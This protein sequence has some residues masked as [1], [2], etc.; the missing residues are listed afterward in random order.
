MGAP[1]H[2][3]YIFTHRPLDRADDV[4]YIHTHINGDEDM[5]SYSSKDIIKKIEDKGWSEVSQKGSHKQFKH[6]TLKGRVTVPANEKDL[7]IGT[8]KSIHKQAG[9]PWPPE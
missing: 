6:D 5:T 7:P 1:T 8:V 2:V 4:V 3:V 9:L